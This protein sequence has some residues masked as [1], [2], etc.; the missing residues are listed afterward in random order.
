MYC[1]VRKQFISLGLYYANNG[2]N[3]AMKLGILIH[4]G[5]LYLLR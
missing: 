3:W 2:L 4:V 5:R 1:I